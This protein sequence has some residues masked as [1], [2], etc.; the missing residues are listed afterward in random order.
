MAGVVGGVT[1]SF[2]NL[3]RQFNKRMQQES[4]AAEGRYQKHYG[5]PCIKCKCEEAARRRK[6]ELLLR[7]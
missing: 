6:S 4:I 5:E 3:F 1:E 7:K 2:E